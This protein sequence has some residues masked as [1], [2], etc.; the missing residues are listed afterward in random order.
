VS[1]AIGLDHGH[2]LRSSPDQS[3]DFADVVGDSPEVYVSP[4][5]GRRRLH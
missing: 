2:Q 3:L 1:V 5:D 4:F